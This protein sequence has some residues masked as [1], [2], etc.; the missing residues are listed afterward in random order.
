MKKL[1]IFNFILFAGL[2]SI[3]NMSAQSCPDGAYQWSDIATIF[4]NNGC[5]VA[6]CHGAD[7]MASGLLLTTYDGFLAGGNKCMGDIREG[8]TLVDIIQNGGVTCA[9]GDIMLPMN[10]F[11]TVPVPE[12]DIAVLQA[13]LDAG[14]F[15]LCRGV[16]ASDGYETCASTIDTFAPPFI[17]YPVCAD[18]RN[19]PEL[20]IP[21]G[22]L[23]NVQVVVE[24]NG[25]LVTVS[26][27][28]SFDSTILK[29]G[30]EICYTAFTY[31]LD[32]INAL[33]NDAYSICP[34]L[35]GIFPDLMPCDAIEE[36]VNGTNENGGEPGLDDLLEVLAFA[37][38]LSTP[39]TSVQSATFT[40]DN[41]NAEI[42]PFTLGPICYATSNSVCV[43]I[44][45]CLS[46]FDNKAIE[47]GIYP[48]P[49]SQ[50]IYVDMDNP[51]QA[52]K[53]VNLTGKIVGDGIS[54]NNRI[55]IS[56]LVDGIYYLQ[57]KQSNTT[58]IA[59]LFVQN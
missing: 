14:A 27:D 46:I 19:L 12:E 38:T 3:Q 1:I 18:A 41:L 28:G 33:L 57:I 22:S 49:A 55:E 52:Y 58:K 26:D 2:L 34:E 54:K 7:L 9:E 59:K 45:P 17:E 43:D 15:E 47:I 42:V 36:L 16:A 53:I 40:L 29:G 5:A 30:D 13:W 4:E 48:N 24:L 23:G 35:D 11:T 50:S 39:I 20:V 6:T 44:D 31:N 10:N 37:S 51:E 8:T 32:T 25:E 56:G 21:A